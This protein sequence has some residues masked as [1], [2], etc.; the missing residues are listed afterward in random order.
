MDLLDKEP[1]L[2]NLFI[3]G[4]FHILI[5]EGKEKVLDK[6]WGD[7]KGQKEQM[8]TLEVARASL[9][10]WKDLWEADLPLL[11]S[12]LQFLYVVWQHGHKH[13]VLIEVT[14]Q[15]KEFWSQMAAIA[16]EVLGP[17]P[18]YVANSFMV[19]DDEHHSGLHQQILTL[20]NVT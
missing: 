17:Y 13:K 10:C 1:A 16:W 12:I 18:D 4:D 8:T 19:L 3:A 5:G 9:G 15:D 14:H 2:A 6:T 11:A 20:L 7:A